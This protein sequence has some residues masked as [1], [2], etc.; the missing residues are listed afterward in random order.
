MPGVSVMIQ[1]GDSI[2]RGFPVFGQ[3]EI[4]IITEVS[5]LL[6]ESDHVTGIVAS[7]WSDL[8]IVTQHVSRITSQSVTLGSVDTLIYIMT[9]PY[10]SFLFVY[11]DLCLETDLL[12]SKFTIV[13]AVTWILS[14]ILLAK[15]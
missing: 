10:I 15:S 13:A 14:I 2:V 6:V 4:T 5:F 11:F 1:R 12:G 9:P 3:S 7:D 8:T